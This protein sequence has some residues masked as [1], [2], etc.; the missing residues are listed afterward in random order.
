MYDII[1]KESFVLF[2]RE[3]SGLDED[4]PPFPPKFTPTV[5]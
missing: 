4:I 3:E 2:G 1:V 5:K